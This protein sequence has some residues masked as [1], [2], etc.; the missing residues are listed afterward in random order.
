MSVSERPVAWIFLTGFLLF[1]SLVFSV[2]CLTRAIRFPRGKRFVCA[3]VLLIAVSAPLMLSV[4][5]YARLQNRPYELR[6]VVYT[7]VAAAPG[8]PLLLLAGALLLAACVVL[9]L[10]IRWASAQLSEQAVYEG[11]DSLPEGVCFGDLRGQPMLVN[12]Q[13]H[14][15]LYAAF[16]L[17]TMDLNEIRR[18]LTAGRL[19]TGCETATYAGGVYLLLPDGTVWDLREKTIDT[20]YGSYRE[21]LA[22]NV[23]DLYRGTEELKVRNERLAAVN[24]QIREYRKNLDHTVREREILNAK[25]RLHDDF[26]KALLAIRSYLTGK[27]SDREALLTLLKTPV[28]LFRRE[29]PDSDADDPLALLEEAA[30]AVGVAIRYRGDLPADHK[31]VLA[32]AIHECIT[33]TVKH[34]NGHNLYISS[35]RDGDGWTVEFTNDGAPPVSPVAETGGLGNLRAFCERAGC[36]MWI[37]SAPRFRLV[38]RL[39]QEQKGE[40]I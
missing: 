38:L 13:M 26:G 37:E 23:T 33:N 4:E 20:R 9:F 40:S 35:R 15:I 2:I 10:F 27:S 5:H 34:A 32:V 14:E 1:L 3:C 6:R 7:L 36:G 12:N 8:L 22:F 29:A 30:A 24:E 11:L 19:R 17:A 21:L 31:E 25:I 28:F 39:P 16:G 18:R